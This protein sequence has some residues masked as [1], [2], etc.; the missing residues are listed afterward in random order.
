MADDTMEIVFIVVRYDKQDETLVGFAKKYKIPWF[1][2]KN[3]NSDS[4]LNQVKLYQADLFV[5][6]SFNQ[7]FK[8]EI[9][10]VPPLKII[11][12]HAGK[13]PFYRGRNVLNWVLI[14]DEKE[15]GITVHYVDQGIDTGDIILQQTYGI[16]DQDTYATLL[17]KAYSECAKLLYEAIKLIQNR[18]VKVI[19]Q[20]DIDECGLYCGIRQDGDE[21]IDW[22]QSSRDIFN[23][24]RALCRPGPQAA[25]YIRGEKI[26]LNKAEMVKGAHVY[27]N[28]TGQVTGITEQ[29]FYVKTK[30][31]IIEITEYTFNIKVRIGDRLTSVSDKTQKTGEAD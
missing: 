8:S 1:A 25:S 15:F 21:I 13:L 23:F 27:K 10:R 26:L 11:N 6:L 16:T 9:L 20:K 31:T 17:E 22:N 30:D 5:S 12:C 19:R 3:V 18:Q 29:G 4:F 28:T 14:N 7:I 24:V 2:H